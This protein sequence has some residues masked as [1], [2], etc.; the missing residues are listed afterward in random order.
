MAGNPFARMA[1]RL[2]HHLGRP[3]L[4][5]GTVATQASLEHGVL[6][7]GEYGQVTGTVSVATLPVEASPRQHDA[8]E[9]DGVAYVLDKLERSDGYLLRFI[10]RGA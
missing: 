9:V 8:L 6:V 7:Y 1:G 3:A 2:L 4:L 5:R 10:L